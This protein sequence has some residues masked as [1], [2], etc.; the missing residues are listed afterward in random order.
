M[1]A[2]P[3]S[4]VR[5]FRATRCTVL[6]LA[7]CSAAPR[8]A[9]APRPDLRAEAAELFRRYGLAIATPTRGTIADAYASAGAVRVINGARRVQ[10]RAQLDSSYRGPWTPP[11]YFAWDALTYDVLGPASVAVSGGFFWKAQGRADTMRY[12]YAAV[13]EREPTGR[14]AIRVEVETMAPP[15]R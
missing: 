6:L 13:L 15:R 1:R 2:P 7:A 3:S 10:T 9:P 8:S 4:A 14:L 12:L 5:S 11:E